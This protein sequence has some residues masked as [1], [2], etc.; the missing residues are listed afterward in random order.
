MNKI[1]IIEDKVDVRENIIEL[2]EAEDFETY[3]A[4]DGYEGIC[5]AQQRHPDLILCDV[6][7]PQM[8][9]YE[10]LNLLRQDPKTAIIPFVFLTAKAGK[11]DVR[12]GM[13][14]GA[15]DYLTK[16]FT[17]AELLEALHTRLAKKEVQQQ[18]LEQQLVGLQQ[19]ISTGIPE[20]IFAPLAEVV[21][22]AQRLVQDAPTIQPEDIRLLGCHVQKQAVFFQQAVQNY[23]LLTQLEF[24]ARDTESLQKVK[25]AV[26]PYPGDLVS[27]VGMQKA[28]Q[29]QRSQDSLVELKNTPIAME[30]S[31]LKKVAAAILD[32][33]L[34]A[35]EP[36]TPIA[37]QTLDAAAD[38]T[39]VIQSQVP[40]FPAEVMAQL[41][42]GMSPERSLLEEIDPSLG[43]LVAQRILDLYGGKMTFA[44]IPGQ[45]LAIT[46][47]MPHA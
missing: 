6:M 34:L 20:K 39:C 11:E 24:L 7:M 38:Y 33:V 40:S 46:I 41:Q 23:F 45:L 15:D 5:L 13:V 43:L 25:T 42:A 32:Y 12:Q 3:A 14:L 8:D 19:S 47:S 31:A 2:L 22:T 10:V 18:H 16:P 27:V 35:S 30:T 1:L 44:A 37:M 29:Y 4:E 17:R 9:G 36:G 28:K 26:T 21:Q